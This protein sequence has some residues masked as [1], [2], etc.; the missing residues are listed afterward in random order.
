MLHAD[1]GS[2]LEFSTTFDEPPV[3]RAAYERVL[4][5]RTRFGA[6]FNE[7]CFPAVLLDLPIPSADPSLFPALK[8]V[9]EERLAA[10]SETNS[11]P[12]VSAVRARI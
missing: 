10:R 11:A 3:L 12:I 5:A 4:G 1:A 7:V 8:Q 9:A 6:D 2:V